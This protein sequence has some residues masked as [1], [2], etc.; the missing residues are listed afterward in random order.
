MNDTTPDV[1]IVGAGPYGLSLAA[2]LRVRGVKFRI[3]GPPMKTWRDEMPPGMLLKSDG[4]A[5]NLSDPGGVCTLGQFC[6]ERGEPYDDRK[7]PVRLETFVNYGLAFQKRMVPELEEDWVAGIDKNGAGFQLTLQSGEQVRARRVV[8]AIGI[9]CYAYTPPELAGLGPERVIHTSL[10]NDG[11]RFRGKKVTVVGAGA[12]AMDTAAYLHESG[13]EVCVIARSPNIYFG[14]PPSPNPRPR[15]LWQRIRHPSSGIGTSLRSR[16]YC[17]APWLFHRLPERLRLRIVK[18][19]LG[20]ASGWPLRER[21]MG[22][23]PLYP[24]TVI[25]RAELAGDGVVLTLAGPDGVER[26]QQTDIVVTG[27]GY[28]VDLE[29]L[30]FL[31]AE[32]QAGIRTVQN[33]PVLS[34]NFESSLSGLYFTG[35]SA[36]NSFGPVMRFAFGADYTARKL[37][38]HLAARSRWGGGH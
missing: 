35:V 7:I 38:G 25:R 36:A 19:H 22:R 12:S 27:T 6:R 9:T 30:S 10:C 17:D 2:H 24:S 3:F 13:A 5:S 11:S 8:L 20:P 33:T 18:R 32:L 26:A 16:I 1:A 4:F 23:V 37:A 29:R 21:V 28:R 34:R 15:S 14:E 31:P